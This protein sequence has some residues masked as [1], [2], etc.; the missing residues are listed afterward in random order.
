ML[1]FDNRFDFHQKCISNTWH[2]NVSVA[3]HTHIHIQTLT[4]HF[5]NAMCSMSGSWKALCLAPFD[6]FHVS[7]AKSSSWTTWMCLFPPLRVCVCIRKDISKICADSSTCN[8]FITSMGIVFFW[9]ATT[10]YT[11]QQSCAYYSYRI[12]TFNP[13]EHCIDT[14]IELNVH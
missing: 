7:N 9:Q 14:K 4:F 2:L 12:P 5:G 3:M 6:C 8:H 13:V 10:R 1:Y 11:Y